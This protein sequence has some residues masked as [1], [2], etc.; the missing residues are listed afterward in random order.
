MYMFTQFEDK[1]IVIYYRYV[2]IPHNTMCIELYYNIS[3]II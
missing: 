3:Y 2:K 1:D